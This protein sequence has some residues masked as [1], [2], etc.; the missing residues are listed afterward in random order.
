MKI[1]KIFLDVYV[2]ASCISEKNFFF[3]KKS[4]QNHFANRNAQLI[5]FLTKIQL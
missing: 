1:S 4:V 3:L 2:Q 5:F